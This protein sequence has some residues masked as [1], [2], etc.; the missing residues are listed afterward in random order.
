M[1]LLE[2]GRTFA[3]PLWPWYLSGTVFL[4]ITNLVTLWIPQLAK[5]II[6][7]LEQIEKGAELQKIAAFIVTLGIAQIIVRSLSRILIFWPGRKV[8]ET[9]KSFL[10][11]RTMHLPQK[12]FDLFGMGDLISRL[13][14]DLGQV[15]VF[16]AFAILQLLNL[17]F[18]AL[19][20]ISMMISVHPKLTLICLVPISLM[21]IL[22]RYIMPTLAR[23]SRESQ[24]AVGRLTNKVTEA[25]TNIHVLKANAAEKSFSNRAEIENE[26]V[27]MANMRVIIFR[28]LFFPLLTSLTGISTLIVVGYGGNQVVE[29]Q[30]TI[31]DILAFNIYLGYLA[32]P[33]TSI[34]IILSI[35][36][37]SKTAMTRISPVVLA[38]P[39]HSPEI[40]DVTQLHP[41]N[42]V[43]SIRNLNFSFNKEFDKNSASG[44]K[45]FNLKQIS[46]EVKKGEMIGICG[47]V[48]SGK[49]TLFNLIMRL[50]ETPS[51][52]IFLH[53]QDITKM[54]PQLLRKKIG[55]G[56]QEIH[57]FSD[58]I[59]ANL[60]FGLETKP[61]FEEIVLACKKAQIYD[62]IMS[63]PSKWQT[64]IGEK[65]VRLSGGQKQRIALARLFLRE[66]DLYIFDDVFSALD[67]QTEA[68]LVNYL[69][70]T[71]ATV[72]VSS[73]R[74]SILKICDKTI[75]LCDGQLID[76]G[77]YNELIDRRPDLREDQN[78]ND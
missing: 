35:Y 15:R 39:E 77:S 53:Q 66:V 48:G 10:F 69:Q 78:A 33:L 50:R 37:R 75:Y 72:L 32:F 44:E 20:T 23:F 67:N 46:F 24:E 49:S 40:T 76:Q 59:L 71:D 54:K 11:E 28:T 17:V 4:A 74:A 31:G 13:S 29:N 51:A 70:H 27:Y 1:N 42:T 8:E 68:R 18:I 30:L 60:E 58:T 2:F 56:L 41:S 63:F 45:H 12:F 14:N 6:N 65:G 64:Q 16:F 52:S 38:E 43:L 34:G 36:Q 73:H 55:Y 57:L 7:Q 25:F 22:T 5:Q 3:K 26:A 47:P 9:S 19:F 62:E 61:S 21:L